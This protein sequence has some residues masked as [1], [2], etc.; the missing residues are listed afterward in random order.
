VHSLILSLI[1]PRR[2]KKDGEPGYHLNHTLVLD[3]SFAYFDKSDERMKM[4]EAIEGR[5]GGTE[6][7]VSPWR[8]AVRARW[9]EIVFI[10]GL[11]VYAILAVLAHR[12]AY[13]DWDLTFAARIQ[14]I[15]IPGFRTLMIWVSMLGSGWMPTA[16]VGG[17]GL[18]MIAAR[19][20]LEGAICLIGVALGAGMNRLLKN[21]IGRPRPGDELINVI[22][23]YRHESFPSGHV[24][25]F[26]EYF[27]FLF[28]LA[29]VLL[30]RGRLRRGSLALL[31]LLIALVGVSRVYMGAHW[32]SDVLGAYLAGGVWLMLMI[33]IYRRLKPRETK[34]AQ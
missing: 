9:A 8:A 30:R 23:Q 26:I 13:F 16:L 3:L 19:F 15:D 34:I 32:P 1:L 24:V 20:R 4:N 5:R 29:Y 7:T 6:I 18:T 21:I 28:F 11:S 14:S 12:Y 31:G 17:A 25:F 10:V 22:T 33:E 27:G 2:W